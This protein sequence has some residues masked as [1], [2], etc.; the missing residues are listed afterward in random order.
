MVRKI[1]N[2]S[3]RLSFGSSRSFCFARFGGFRGA[4]G[5]STVTAAGLGSA[6]ATVLAVKTFSGKPPSVFFTSLRTLVSLMIFTLTGAQASSLAIECNRDGCAPV[7]FA[8]AQAVRNIYALKTRSP[9]S[10][11]TP[12]PFP[13]AHARSPLRSHVDR[14]PV[15]CPAGLLVRTPA[16]ACHTHCLHHRQLPDNARERQS[17][18]SL[19][20]PFRIPSPGRTKQ[21]CSPDHQRA[22]VQRFRFLMRPFITSQ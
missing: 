19:R 17:T 12:Q 16:R 8:I 9:E 20:L 21:H 6:F 11:G 18:Y 14:R 5:F 7:P 1:F 4:G 10:A 15:L 22:S 13:D 3:S 2:I